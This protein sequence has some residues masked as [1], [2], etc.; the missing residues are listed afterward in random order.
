M[1]RRMQMEHLDDP[2]YVK[3]KSLKEKYPL[4]NFLKTP[5]VKEREKQLEKLGLNYDPTMYPNEFLP[6]DPAYKKLLRHR[7]DPSH[8]VDSDDD[9]IADEFLD[10]YMDHVAEVAQ[11]PEKRG[12]PPLQKGYHR[13]LPDKLF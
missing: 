1:A 4:N 13:I 12:T 7:D 2:L 3:Q 6:K 8:W 11:I 10:E 5:G 9:D